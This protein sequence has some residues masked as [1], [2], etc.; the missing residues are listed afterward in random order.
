[1]QQALN[2]GKV[3]ADTRVLV[4]STASGKLALLTDQMS[5]HHLAQGT[6][7]GKTWMATF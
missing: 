6:E 4:L 2:E 7:G 3:A 5:F 1:L